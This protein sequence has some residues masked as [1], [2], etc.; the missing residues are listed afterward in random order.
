MDLNKLY[1]L[2]DE[3]RELLKDYKD[4]DEYSQPIVPRDIS[5]KLDRLHFDQ[6]KIFDKRYRFQPSNDYEWIIYHST[7]KEV[8]FLRNKYFK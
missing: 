2:F 8:S 6:C 4:I 3:E 5:Y 7:I 1:K